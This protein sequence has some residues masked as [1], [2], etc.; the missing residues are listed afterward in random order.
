MQLDVHSFRRY[1]YSFSFLFLMA[2]K[3]WSASITRVFLWNTNK[4]RLCLL[5]RVTKSSSK[6]SKKAEL[7]KEWFWWLENDSDVKP[8]Y[9]LKFFFQTFHSLDL[10]LHCWIS[11]WWF[12]EKALGSVQVISELIPCIQWE[13]VIQKSIKGCFCFLDPFPS[14]AFRN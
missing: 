13:S 7:S 8:E 2:L 11:V 14:F 1:T 9:C 4:P 10:C 6:C 12:S 3:S 5:I